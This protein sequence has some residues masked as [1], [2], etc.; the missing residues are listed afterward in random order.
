M[1]TPSPAIMPLWRRKGRTV[2]TGDDV[3]AYVYD[4]DEEAARVVDALNRHVRSGMRCSI[5][6]FSGQGCT[7]PTDAQRDALGLQRSRGAR[8]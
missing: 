5:N 3:V 2:Y 6:A 4:T 8:R 7:H 1:S